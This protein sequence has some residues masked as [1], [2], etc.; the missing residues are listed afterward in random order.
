MRYNIQ[1]SSSNSSRIWNELI[2]DYN[3][4]NE[5]Y[6][7]S[8]EKTVFLFNMNDIGRKRNAKTL[9]YFSPL[10]LYSNSYRYLF[11]YCISIRSTYSRFFLLFNKKK[12]SITYQTVMA[13]FYD[14]I[15]IQFYFRRYVQ[16][17]VHTSS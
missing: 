2:I 8:R 12:K 4:V 5:Y 13:R 15:I 1:N 9:Y 7:Q 14:D 16:L 17:Q 6:F 3:L 11:T 10:F